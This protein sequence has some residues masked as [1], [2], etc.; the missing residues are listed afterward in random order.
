MSDIVIASE[1]IIMATTVNTAFNEFLKETVRLD[2]DMTLK[3]RKSR[4][5]LIDNLNGFSGDEDFF[6]LYSY[7]D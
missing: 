1:G 3:A 7:Y 5:N 2:P 6:N 4:D